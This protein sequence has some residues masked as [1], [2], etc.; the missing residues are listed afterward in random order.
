MLTTTSNGI[1][2][3]EDVESSK[4]KPKP[5][6]PR[7]PTKSSSTTNV[8]PPAVEQNQMELEE[9]ADDLPDHNP[10][11]DE[12]LADIKPDYNEDIGI[13]SSQEVL[14]SLLSRRSLSKLF[15]QGTDSQQTQD[16]SNQASSDADDIPLT[17]RNLIRAHIVGQLKAGPMKIFICKIGLDL[18]FWYEI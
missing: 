9:A 5:E 15:A 18:Y 7:S 8:P 16:D 6:P 10:V 4:V 2:L 3:Q 1:C 13:L 11:E 17:A 12:D 14:V